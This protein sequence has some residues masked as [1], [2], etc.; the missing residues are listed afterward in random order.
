MAL[1]IAGT[2]GFTPENLYQFIYLFVAL[3]PYIFLAKQYIAVISIFMVYNYHIM[4]R[5][6]QD[7]GIPDIIWSNYL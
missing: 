5:N 7:L 3:I 4:S 6:T 1:L 2:M